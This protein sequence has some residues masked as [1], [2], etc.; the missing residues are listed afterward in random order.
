MSK[1]I[2]PLNAFNRQEVLE[3]GQESYISKIH[4][5]GACGVEIRREL[6][7]ENSLPLSGIREEL[8]KYPLFTVYSAPIELWLNDGS[9]N[10]KN[11]NQ[12][13]QE[14]KEIGASWIKVSLGHFINEISDVRELKDF[15]IKEENIQLLVENDQTLHGGCIQNFKSFFESANKNNLPVKMTFDIGNWF[16]S[17]ESVQDAIDS[18]KSNVV[19]LHLKHVEEQENNLITLPLPTKERA[20]WRRMLEQFPNGLN[21]ALEIPIQTMEQLKYFIKLVEIDY[22]KRQED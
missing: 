4:E 2:V 10:L 21:R 15:L 14:A 9:M 17:G 18:L 19:Y 11:L 22:L 5:A 20:D 12:I 8:K 1:V 13:Y 7:P 6:F 3:K 16:Y